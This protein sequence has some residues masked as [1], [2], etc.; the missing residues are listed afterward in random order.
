MKTDLEFSQKGQKLLMEERV[1]TDLKT[2]KY[3]IHI[4]Q[5]D[6]ALHKIH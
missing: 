4:W 1:S 6:S 5:Y 2:Q 3:S